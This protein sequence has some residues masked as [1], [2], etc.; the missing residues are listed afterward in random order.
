MNWLTRFKTYRILK[1]HGLPDHEWHQVTQNLPL[2]NL[3][4]PAEKT[5]LRVL[6]TLLIYHKTFTGVQGLEMTLAK[7]ITIAAQACIEIL[8]LGIDSFDGWQ[9]VIVYPGAFKVERETRDEF[10]LIHNS[11]NALSGEAWMRGPVILSWDDIER[12]SYT[13][14]KGHHVILHE[15]AHKLDML[16]GRANGMPPLHPDMTISEWTDSLS[17]AYEKLSHRVE[18]H[19]AKINAYAATNPAEFFAVM[20][21]YFFTAPELLIEHY[22]KVYQQLKTYFSLDTL[23]R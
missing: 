11:D 5:R 17:R 20:C 16:N 14:H 8:Q 21:E 4:S 10:G 15:F 9:E 18:T 12:D 1:K 2:L 19:H 7:K 6:S 3:L 13:R 23:N 22:P